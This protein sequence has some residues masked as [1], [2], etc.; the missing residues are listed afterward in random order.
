MAEEVAS[1]LKKSGLQAASVKFIAAGAGLVQKNLVVFR[2]RLYESS[3][4]T[5]MRKTWIKKRLRAT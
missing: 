2:L 5:V 4:T 3:D 1:S